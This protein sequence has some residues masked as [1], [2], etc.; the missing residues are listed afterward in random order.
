MKVANLSVETIEN[1]KKI[2]YDRIRGKHEGPEGWSSILK[3]YDPEFIKIQ[4]YLVLLPVAGE[5]H[6]N[7]TI[8]RSSISHDEQVMTIFLK[9]T[10]YLSD[11]ELEMFEAGFMAVCEKMP[12]E[13]F[14]LATVYHEWFIIETL[15]NQIKSRSL[16]SQHG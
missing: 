4:K 16:S 10:S 3:Y 12:N 8:L 2:R 1:I 13:S 14:Y 7:I 11:P 5:N 9:D 6:P 15:E